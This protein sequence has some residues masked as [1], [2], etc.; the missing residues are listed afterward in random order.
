M[1]FSKLI[2]LE[3]EVIESKMTE[4]NDVQI[5]IK[6]IGKPV[7]DDEGEYL[8]GLKIS[9]ILVTEDTSFYNQDI[10]DLDGN[11]ITFYNYPI[12]RE[13][14]GINSDFFKA[15]YPM[16]KDYLKKNN[17]PLKY[18]YCDEPVAAWDIVNNMKND[19]YEGLLK[20]GEH[21]NY[22]IQ[23]Y[24]NREKKTL[25]FRNANLNKTYIL[26]EIDDN[27]IYEA[28]LSFNKEWNSIIDGK[29]I[30]D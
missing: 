25:E 27:N 9:T 22:D 23:Y 4:D 19:I 15:V 1:K 3:L 26:K 14:F 12:F 21:S 7:E 10:E 18:M 11:F 5:S 8:T 28:M 29:F 30:W 16:V 20:T 17:L 6:I 24:I 2:E 13:L